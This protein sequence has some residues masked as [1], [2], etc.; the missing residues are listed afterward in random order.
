MDRV[1]RL[2]QVF[3]AAVRPASS[4]RL[5][6]FVFSCNLP[7]AAALS[8]TLCLKN[9]MTRSFFLASSTLIQR[10][11]VLCDGPLQSQVVRGFGSGCWDSNRLGDATGG[12]ERLVSAAGGRLGAGGRICR[13]LRSNGQWGIVKR[14]LAAAAASWVR[15]RRR[16][17]P[18]VRVVA[19]LL[20]CS[21][22]FCRTQSQ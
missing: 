1:D 18:Q 22:N 6:A 11:F 4:A 8:A 14:V 3:G 17:A 15:L 7:A 16:E 10:G 5:F 12:L 2:H 13:D 20:H 21:R 9:N 19:A